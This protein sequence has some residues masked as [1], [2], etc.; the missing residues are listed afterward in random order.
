MTARTD[1]VESNKERLRRVSTEI[2]DG[3]NLALV[4]ELFAEDFVGHAPPT[5][6]E[7]RGH[8]GFRGLVAAFRTGFPDLHHTDVHLVGEGDVVVARLTGTGTHEGEFLGVPP[9]GE[10]IEATAMEM[11]RFEDGLIVEAW[12]NVDT[13]GLL[14]QLGAVEG[15]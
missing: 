13:L 7:L 4:D 1:T 2:F 10:T 6:G 9:T 15:V 12:L 14:S 3:G 8:D 11:Y 5:P